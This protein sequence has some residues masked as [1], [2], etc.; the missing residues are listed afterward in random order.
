MCS[1]DCRLL[2]DFPYAVKF[3]SPRCP[4]TCP[5]W[6]YDAHLQDFCQKWGQFAPHIC[7]KP[8]NPF[9][10]VHVPMCSFDKFSK[11]PLFQTS[12]CST[13]FRYQRRA[14]VS[15]F[16]SKNIIPL[17]YFEKLKLN[18]PLSKKLALCSLSMTF[19]TFSYRTMI[20]SHAAA[21][22]A[23]LRPTTAIVHHQ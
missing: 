15:S 22:T 16:H 13:K 3:N 9:M 17:K 8:V 19:P 4:Q 12:K 2:P 7:Q 10:D 5:N 18:W 11:P 6:K 23:C 14:F 1:S 21:Q 20:Q